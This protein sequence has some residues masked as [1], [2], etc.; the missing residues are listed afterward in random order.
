MDDMVEQYYVRKTQ[1]KTIQLETT[2]L[3]TS[4]PVMWKLLTEIIAEKMYEH[5]VDYNLMPEEPKGITHACRGAKDQLL[6]YK[7]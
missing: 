4:L 3:F 6:I 5:L 1:Q 2:G 7:T